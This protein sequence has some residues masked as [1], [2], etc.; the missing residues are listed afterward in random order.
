[1][2][3]AT[4]SAIPR[5]GTGKGAAR[6]LRREGQVPGVIYG[7]ARPSQSLAIPTRELEK[8]LSHISADNTVIELSMDGTNTRALIREIQRHPFKRQILHVDFQEVVAGQK[9]TV[10]VPIMLVG[11]A[12]GVRLHGGIVDHT[13]RELTI[14]VDPSNIPNHIDIDITELDLGQSIH[15]SQIPVPE[16]AAVLDEAEA[17]VVVIATPRAAIETV[18]AE[19]EG[20]SAEPEVIRAKKL[21]EGAAE[22]EKK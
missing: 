13:M 11:T 7:H 3:T 2:A 14:S 22:G 6:S 20:V 5:T 18:A 12:V 8:L 19:G 10:R 21:E 15:V 1:M 9:V 16:G 17:A 4:L